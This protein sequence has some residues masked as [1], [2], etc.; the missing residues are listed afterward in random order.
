MTVATSAE[1][2]AAQKDLTLGGGGDDGFFFEATGRST[3]FS[4]R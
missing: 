3:A 2:I 1:A 4:Y